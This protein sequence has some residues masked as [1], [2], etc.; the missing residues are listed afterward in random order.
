MEHQVLVHANDAVVGATHAHVS[1]ERCSA[2]KYTF[3]CGGDVGMGAEDCG[4][5]AVEVPAHGDFFAG[6]FS[7]EI[8]DNDFGLDS[9]EEIGCGVKGV[10]GPAHE[11]L[12]HEVEY[13]VWLPLV[14]PVRDCPFED[15]IAGEAGLHICRAED[16]TG[17][18]LAV[19]W[20]GEVV[21]QFALVPHVVAG[22]H[23]VGAEVEELLGDLGGNAEAAGGVFDIHDGEVDVVGLAQ[24]ADVLAHDP[25][26]R[27]AEDV[28]DE[29]DVQSG[30]MLLETGS[31][32]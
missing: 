24:M 7:V 8:D 16:A 28:A 10:V 11:D 23:D 31:R 29:E 30:S 5:F 9:G 3:V 22:C 4:D 25:A 21:E 13:C 6:G 20:D 17:A 27:A 19:G 15:T 18:F 14:G 1:L 12:A 26:S 32:E 2:G